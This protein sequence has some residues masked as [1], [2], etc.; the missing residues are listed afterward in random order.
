ME[1]GEIHRHR[2]LIVDDEPGIR[3]LLRAAFTRAGFEV[4][5]APGVP[6]A[7]TICA[8]ETFDAVLSDV[9]MP[10][11][12]GY[13]LVCWLTARYPGTRVMLMSG[14]DP[15]CGACAAAA[16][17]PLLRKPFLPDQAIAEIRFLL[18]A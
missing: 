13:D 17:C 1:S 12:S 14:F 9:R 7:M 4:R 3:S 8:S 6:E 18:A 5:T 10:G 11:Q 16:K 15:D 2:V